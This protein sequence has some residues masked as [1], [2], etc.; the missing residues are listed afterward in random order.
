MD[1]EKVRDLLKRAALVLEGT[2]TLD[3]GS[4]YFR[5][6]DRPCQEIYEVLGI[7]HWDLEEE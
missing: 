5:N 6:A 4:A 7:N 2:L 3:C 1:E